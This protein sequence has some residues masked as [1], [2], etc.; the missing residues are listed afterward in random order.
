MKVVALA[1]DLGDRARIQG[2][3]E[4]VAFVN[5]AALLPAAARDA[6]LVL[7]DLTR[8]GVL[9][10]LDD[11]VAVA[12]RVVAFGPHV[13]TELLA[14]ATSAGA[15]AV[16]RSRLFGGKQPFIGPKQGGNIPS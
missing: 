1:P 7:V 6:D 14:A 4:D 5:A 16:P 2:M 12:G 3:V 13:A 11:V 15:E 9:E 8:A 10:V